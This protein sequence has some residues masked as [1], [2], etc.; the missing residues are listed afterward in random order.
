MGFG[1]RAPSRL[2]GLALLAILFVAPDLLADRDTAKTRVSSGVTKYYNGDFAGAEGDFTN[3]M[4]DDGDDTWAVP[5]NNRGLARLKQGRFAEALEDFADAKERDSA[6]VAPYINA[7]KCYAA[8]KDWD[9]AVAQLNA[10]LVKS[11]NNPKLLYNLGWVRDAQG[12]ETAAATHFQAAIAANA[13]H[14]KA[15][16]CLG[17]ARARQGDDAAAVTQFYRAITE[18]ETDDFNIQ[19]AA[20][21]LQLLRG[22]GQAF[23]TAQAADDYYEGIFLFSVEQYTAAIARL[24]AAQAAAVLVA[25]V[26]WMIMWCRTKLR[27]S[28]QAANDL[29]AARA[30]MPTL[31]VRS[32]AAGAGV[33]VDG[34]PRGPTPVA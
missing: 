4:A 26:P 27:Q 2:A 20:Y 22:N 12:N 16:I 7:A 6:Y 1:K 11:P 13:N 10:G 24:Q 31:T 17:I 29:Q 28:T 33:E 9:N 5:Y 23:P 32:R 19:I 3:A 14:T 25:D 18:A 15:K 21:D 30:L 34:L 8:Q